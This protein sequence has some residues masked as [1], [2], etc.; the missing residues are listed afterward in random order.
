M[1]ATSKALATTGPAGL[2]V[3]PVSVVKVVDG[4]IY[5]Y[6]FFMHKTVEN[7]VVEPVVSLV[8]WNGLVGIQVRAV[9]SYETSGECFAATVDEMKVRFPDRTL[10]GVI[11]LRP[12]AVF[13]ISAESTRAGV[14]LAP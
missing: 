3:V 11:A 10:S 7:L 14:Q 4:V 2:N 5:L 13:D 12:T 6:N 8:C 9:A 1:S